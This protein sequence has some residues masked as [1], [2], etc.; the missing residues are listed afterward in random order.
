MAKQNRNV[1]RKDRRSQKAQ[2]RGIT[3]WYRET[4]GEL[5]KVSWPTRKEALGLTRVV[6][7][8]LVVMSFLLGGV[9]LLFSQLFDLILG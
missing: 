6:L 5:R 2:P 1:T 4:V 9:D 8:V 7:V 3:K